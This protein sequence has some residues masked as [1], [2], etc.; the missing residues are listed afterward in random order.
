MQIFLPSELKQFAQSQIDSGNYESI[1]AMLV[2]GLKLLAER[3]ESYQRRFEMLRQDVM[4]GVGAADRGELLDF[5]T[6]ME[7]I[8]LSLKEKH[9]LERFSSESSKAYQDW[10]GTENDIYDEDFADELATR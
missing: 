7:N 3:D 6:E 2:A 8:R 1:E 4:I 9:R 10:A 5:D